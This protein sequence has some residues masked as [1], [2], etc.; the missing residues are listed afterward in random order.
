MPKK[1]TIE[2]FYVIY[3]IFIEFH[4]LNFPNNDDITKN[5][6]YKFSYNYINCYIKQL[7]KNRQKS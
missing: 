2:L 4:E 3:A 1:L 5:Y 6:K 7:F